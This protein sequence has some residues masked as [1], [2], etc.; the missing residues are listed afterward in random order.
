MLHTK[1]GRVPAHPANVERLL[2]DEGQ[3]V[4]AFPEGG[5]KPLSERYR[6]RLFDTL[7]RRFVKR[8]ALERTL[9]AQPVLANPSS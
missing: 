7:D 1:L 8:A 2:A 5:T 6:L 3:L 9:G 4:L